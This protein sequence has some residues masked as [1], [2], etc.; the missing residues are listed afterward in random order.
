MMFSSTRLPVTRHL[1]NG[2]RTV[3]DRSPLIFFLHNNRFSI[4][5]SVRTHLSLCVR[6]FVCIYSMCV[7]MHAC[8]FVCI[9]VLCRCM[10]IGLGVALSTVRSCIFV[11]RSPSLYR[12]FTPKWRHCSSTNPILIHP[13]LPTFL[14]V[15]TPNPIA[16]WLLSACLT[17]CSWPTA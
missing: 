10:Y 15:S 3:I 6:V 5:I 17:L 2:P 12:S 13:F 7:C 9:Y 11:Y 16:V 8:I 14:P 4:L 1:A